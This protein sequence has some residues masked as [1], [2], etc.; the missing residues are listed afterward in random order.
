[1]TQS[2]ATSAKPS[3]TT[4]AAHRARSTRLPAYRE[5]PPYGQAIVTLTDAKTKQR[6]DFWLGE[7]GSPSSREAYN[8]TIVQWLASNRL[9][10]GIAVKTSAE[11]PGSD[12]AG[13]TVNE[14]ALAY[15][16]HIQAIEGI[17]AQA[18]VRGMI[19]LVR[20]LFGNT[21]AI[22]FGPRSLRLVR[23]AMIK[24]DESSN[25][26]TP[27]THRK[28][29]SRPYINAQV[30]R[31]CGPI[32]AGGFILDMGEGEIWFW[33]KVCSRSFWARCHEDEHGQVSVSG[34]QQRE[35]V[36]DPM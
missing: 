28:P 13:I 24:G 14:L 33:C 11:V 17:P 9:L 4:R 25:S 18:H 2:H 32:R 29:W 22:E 12:A 10:T 3:R 36:P 30:H 34:P 26:P 1:M 8:R 5:R 7:Y 6:K 15:W 20:Q 19:R 35:G 23:E 27:P 31:L 16:K 21:P